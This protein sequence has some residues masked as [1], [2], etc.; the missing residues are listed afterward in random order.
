MRWSLVFVALLI[1]S[2]ASA[3]LLLSEDF[4]TPNL[5]EAGWF[6]ID[7][8]VVLTPDEAYEG[9]RSM[10]FTLQPEVQPGALLRKNFRPTQS[11]FLRFA[12]KYEND[13]FWPADN[14]ILSD[15]VLFANAEVNS[16]PNLSYLTISVRFSD[17]YP[18][19]SVLDAEQGFFFDGTDFRNDARRVAGGQWYLIELEV[20]LNDPGQDNG[21]L[22]L[23]MDD[24]VLIEQSNLRLRA[25]GFDEILFDQI[26]I[27]WHNA[28]VVLS[29][30]SYWTDAIAIA[31]VPFDELGED[32][33]PGE[34]EGEAEGD[35][36]AEGEAE[37]D[38]EMM[39]PPGT[40]TPT[41]PSTGAPPP[42][43]DDGCATAGGAAP[44]LPL[45]LLALFAL[46]PRRRE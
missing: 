22:V 7:P 42:P 4:D 11:V 19:V 25:P 29:E 45:V 30:Q 5:M 41:G 10:Q 1:A 44:F 2:P 6:D 34:G 14:D 21:R 3:E 16:Q 17:G 13:W 43:R 26:A 37:G 40:T 27:G 36:E 39:M 15:V 38:D 9:N 8:N 20:R 18:A 24:E 23:R 32:P 31:T 28:D 33:T 46:G 12:R 35:G